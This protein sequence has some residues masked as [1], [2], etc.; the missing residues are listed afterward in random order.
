MIRVLIADNDRLFRLGAKAIFERTRNIAVVAETE[1]G[2]EALKL[3]GHQPVDVVILEISLPGQS[4]L[5]TLS[6]MRKQYRRLP[7][8][9]VTSYPEGLYGVRAMKH[10][11]SG[12]LVKSCSAEQLVAALKHCTTGHKYI[13]S[14]LAQELLGVCS[15]KSLLPHNLLS[16]REFAIFL[17]TAQGWSASQ[18]ADKICISSI[19]VRKGRQRM[20]KALGANGEAAI[21]RYVVQNRVSAD[22]LFAHVDTQ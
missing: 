15:Y 1:T 10:G 17:F 18:I 3:L 20:L 13:T 7:V 4:G 2:H 6:I 22:Y 19:T 21:V 14:T 11:A 9:F 5:E 12:Y 16:D 8:L